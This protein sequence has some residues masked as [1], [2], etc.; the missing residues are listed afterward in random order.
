MSSE[1]RMEKT[2]GF[3]SRYLYCLGV[4]GVWQACGVKTPDDSWTLHWTWQRV[5]LL[6]FW[7]S[8]MHKDIGE[9]IH[10]GLSESPMASALSSMSSVFTVSFHAICLYYILPSS[11]F[12]ISFHVVCLY[13]HTTIT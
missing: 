7:G 2:K 11:V 5:I 13:S 6:E 8:S 9:L 4:P 10:I 1:S 12:T 3:L